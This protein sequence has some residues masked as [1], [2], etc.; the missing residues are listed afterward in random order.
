MARRSVIQTVKLETY[1]EF[2]KGHTH[3]SLTKEFL[4]EVLFKRMSYESFAF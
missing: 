3:T 1:R 4:F 2:V